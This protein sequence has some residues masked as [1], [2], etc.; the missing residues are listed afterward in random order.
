EFFDKMN[1]D[2]GVLRQIK[3]NS[4]SMQKSYVE[5]MDMTSKFLDQYVKMRISAIKSFDNYIHIMVDSYTNMLSQF[6]KSYMKK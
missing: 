2:Q 6:N 1:I 3:A 5:N 4:E